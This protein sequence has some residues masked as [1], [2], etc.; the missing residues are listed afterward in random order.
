MPS[1]SLNLLFLCSMNQ[2]RSPTAERI[3]GRK[4]FFNARS[5]G[6]SSKARHRVSHTDLHWADVIFV[7]ENKHKRRLQAKYPELMRYQ[8]VHVL[9]IQDNY[10]FMDPELVDILQRSIDPILADY[11]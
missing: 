6:T 1:Q 4:P 10:K 2:W 3:Y 8:N 7:M 9:D 5:G 11:S